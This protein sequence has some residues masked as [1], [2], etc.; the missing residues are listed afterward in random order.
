[1]LSVQSVQRVLITC[2]EA[3]AGQER[4]RGQLLVSMPLLR[5]PKKIANL[6]GMRLWRNGLIPVDRWHSRNDVPPIFRGSGSRRR[7]EN[8]NSPVAVGIAMMWNLT[9]GVHGASKITFRLV[10][11]KLDTARDFG[12]GDKQLS[13]GMFQGD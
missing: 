8:G 11:A 12:F 2:D 13:K 9:E 3:P 7:S 4:R 10:L 1:M 6:G 5:H